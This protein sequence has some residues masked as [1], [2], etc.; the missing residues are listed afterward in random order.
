MKK[1]LY[2]ETS[3]WNQLK[4]SEMPDY[5]ETAEKFFGEVEKGL[6]D[7]FISDAV[8]MEIEKC[9]DVERKNQLLGFI[10]KYSPTLLPYEQESETLRQ[11]YVDTGIM[12]D[13][14]ENKYYDT[15]HVAVATVNQ[16]PYLLTFNYKHFLKIN[17]IEAFNGVNILNGYGQIQLV[18]PELFVPESKSEEL[19]KPQ[20]Q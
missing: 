18:S 6:Y 10:E 8:L 4:Q 20:I 9:T 13:L 12:S 2:I 3:V 7:I 11:K 17:K 19:W 16:M 1:K 5:K 15:A 14:Q